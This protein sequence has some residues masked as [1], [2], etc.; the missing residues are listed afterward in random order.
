MTFGESTSGK[1]LAI[2]YKSCQLWV[3]FLEMVR[4]YGGY[5][6]EQEELRGRVGKKRWMD[7]PLHHPKYADDP[8]KVSP[9]WLGDP[10]QAPVP[11]TP[12]P[13]LPLAP[14]ISSVCLVTCYCPLTFG[15]RGFEPWAS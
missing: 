6:Y 9:L 10:T 12:S 14:S 3:W 7:V 1:L 4:R 8:S 11:C 15:L 13:I 2:R 5:T